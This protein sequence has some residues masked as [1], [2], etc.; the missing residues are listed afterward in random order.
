VGADLTGADLRRARLDAAD[1]RGAS[2]VGA[3]IEATVF[4]NAILDGARWIDGRLCA[5]GSV[6]RCE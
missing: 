5:Q 2:L 3:R 1:L 6:G 4:T